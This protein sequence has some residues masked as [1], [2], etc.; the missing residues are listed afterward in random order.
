MAKPLQVRESEPESVL[1]A[2][3]AVDG[4]HEAIKQKNWE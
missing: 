3:H 1:H 2:A 4:G